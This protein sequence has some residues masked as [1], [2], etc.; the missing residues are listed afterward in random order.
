MIVEGLRLETEELKER[1]HKLESELETTSN[2]NSS[3]LDE[4]SQRSLELTSK[5][6]DAKASCYQVCEEN[7]ELKVTVKELE[8]EIM[9]VSHSY[10][11]ASCHYVIPRDAAFIE[12]L[13]C[14]FPTF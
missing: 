14:P 6:A 3:I 1:I 7:L 8:C 9:E 12:K 11:E 13:H 10:S 5:L 2:A 4:M